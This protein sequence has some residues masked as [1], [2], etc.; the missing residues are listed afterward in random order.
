MKSIR[1]LGATVFISVTTTIS[2]SV[3]AGG[4]TT[5]FCTFAAFLNT[6]ATDVAV[7]LSSNSMAT[8]N[9]AALPTAGVNQNVIVLPRNW[10]TRSCMQC[11]VAHSK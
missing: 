8:A 5:D 9:V 2:G 4:D 10:F 3:S 6:G 11:P 7:A 1:A